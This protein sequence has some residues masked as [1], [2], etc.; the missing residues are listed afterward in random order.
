[1][2]DF[3]EEQQ[4]TIRRAQKLLRLAAGTTSEEEAESAQ[5]KVQELLAEYNLSMSDIPVDD[6]RAQVECDEHVIE[7]LPGNPPRWV[8][9]L[10]TCII[11]IYDID[12]IRSRTLQHDR[13]YDYT[14]SFI[15]VDPEV[16][17]GSQSFVTVYRHLVLKKKL[18][19]YTKKKMEDYCLGFVAGLYSKL[20][21]QK[22][23]QKTTENCTALAVV[24]KDMIAKYMADK[25]A[26][27]VRSH[28]RRVHVDSEAYNNGAIDG[29]AYNISAGV[30][31]SSKQRAVA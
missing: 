20:H 10:A 19:G 9:Q 18:P 29:N 22:E 16:T 14:Y 24:R 13:T 8:S 7:I 21:A 25:Y 30:R 4:R 12:C 15:G 31:A 23:A 5:L 3:S 1:M 27:A 26:G 11:N 17:I 6:Y 28:Q 2:S